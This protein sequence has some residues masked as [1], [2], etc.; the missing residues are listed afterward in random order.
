LVT[1]QKA[2]S[3]NRQLAEGVH[4]SHLLVGLGRDRLSVGHHILHPRHRELSNRKARQAGR[5]R[6]NPLTLRHPP[7]EEEEEEEDEDESPPPQPPPPLDDELELELDEE[8]PPG[9][10]HC[11]ASKDLIHGASRHQ[12]DHH[13]RT[14]R[15]RRE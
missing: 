15:T 7:E 12:S 3:V 5:H 9:T 2:D 11:R 8:P 1:W 4:I 13:T 6:G 14:T 10:N